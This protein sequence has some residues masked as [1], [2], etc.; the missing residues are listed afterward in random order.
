MC[1]CSVSQRFHMYVLSW[2]IH[3]ESW[4]EFVLVNSA[5]GGLGVY[6]HKHPAP[7]VGSSKDAGEVRKMIIPSITSTLTD[8]HIEP[9]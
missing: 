9:L 6:M 3:P 4:R 7:A 2:H 8:A 1:L 5:P